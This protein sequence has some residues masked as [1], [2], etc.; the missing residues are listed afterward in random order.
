MNKPTILI[1][2]D[3]AP[4]RQRLKDLLSDLREQCPHILSGEADNARDALLKVRQ[5]HPDI[6]LLDVQMPEMNGIQ[7]AQYLRDHSSEYGVP[8][9]IYVTAYDAFAV[10]A[11]EVQASDYLVKPVRAARLQDAITRV[12][13]RGLPSAP[14]TSELPPEALRKSHFSVPERG[15]IL[16]VPADD[17]LYLK[18]DQKYVSLHTADKSYLLEDS[19]L[20]IEAAFSERFVRVHRNALVARTA[21]AGA[22]RVVQASDMEGGQERVSE[23]WQVIIAGSPERL[24]VSR[25]QWP[26]I[27][28]L[29]KSEGR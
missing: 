18:A 14:A 23:N 16:L 19:L 2:D 12:V 5:L 1:V 6:L 29:V 25:R 22:E 24:P 20:S 15:R 27:K 10:P 13:Q 11:F 21:I 9:I 17:V 7:M 28:V 3:E 26:V 8:A 4:A